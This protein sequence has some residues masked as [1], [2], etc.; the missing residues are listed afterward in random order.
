MDVMFIIDGSGSIGPQ[1]FENIRQFLNLIVDEMDIGPN[2]SAVGLI[3]F[4]E[5]PYTEFQLRSYQSKAEVKSEI[6]LV[7][8]YIE[9]ERGGVKSGLNSDAISQAQWRNGRT[10]I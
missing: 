2:G 7:Y 1:G 8:I 5:D 6:R 10:M 3:Q 9:R 4:N